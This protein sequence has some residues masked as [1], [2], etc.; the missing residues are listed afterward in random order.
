MRG[1]VL[2]FDPANGTGIILDAGGA[3]LSFARHDWL[4]PGEP[5]PGTVI[6]FTVAGDR[7][8]EIF[9]LPGTGAGTAGSGENTAMVC[10]ILSLV[11]ALLSLLLG[12]FGLITLIAALV[13]G[14]IGKGAGRDL[15]VKTGYYLSIAGLAISAIVLLFVILAIAACSSFMGGMGRVRF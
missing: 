13:F 11:C 15:P 10:G 14:L 9:L 3:R 12:P 6:D 1:T 8:T 2:G 7:A 5:R 4:S